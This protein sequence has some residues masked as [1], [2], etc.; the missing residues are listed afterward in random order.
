MC[1]IQVAEQKFQCHQLDI[2]EKLNFNTSTKNSDTDA[3]GL[4]DGEEGCTYETDPLI[5]DTDGDG[6]SDAAEVEAGTDPKT[7]N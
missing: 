5:S 1:G 7:A 2:F 6:L 4:S 3:D